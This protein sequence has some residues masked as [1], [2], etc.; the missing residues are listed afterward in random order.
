MTTDPT[1]DPRD[2]RPFGRRETDQP[3]RR[4]VDDDPTG[5]IDVLLF[6]RLASA[7]M[8]AERAYFVALEDDRHP[9]V[10]ASRN[11][12]AE[13]LA[14]AVAL[15]L[16]AEV[17]EVRARAAKAYEDEKARGRSGVERARARL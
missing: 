15:L 5:R 16:G 6:A 2:L 8:D 10:E 14:E 11:A 4:P 3:M 13:G 17:V 12:K 9:I 1:I 7:H